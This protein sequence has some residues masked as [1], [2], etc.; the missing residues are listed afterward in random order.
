MFSTANI[1]IIILWVFKILLKDELFYCVAVV[2][3]VRCINITVSQ[4]RFRKLTACYFIFFR[5]TIISLPD[6]IQRSTNRSDFNH[7]C[8]LQL[9]MF[10]PF[11]TER[12]VSKKG[13]LI[14]RDK[15]FID[16]D[17]CLIDRDSGLLTETDGLLTEIGGLLTETGGLLTERVVNWQR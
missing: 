7:L 8:L 16:R 17:T 2:V 10:M 15:W 6:W 1:D 12:W 3:M 9:F 13:G 11:P 5:S 4:I 14:D